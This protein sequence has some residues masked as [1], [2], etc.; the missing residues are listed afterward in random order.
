MYVI[1]FKI[2][3]LLKLNVD[4][5]PMVIVADSRDSCLE[6]R[7]RE[8]SQAE[9]ERLKRKSTGKINRAKI[10]KVEPLFK[11]SIKERMGVCGKFNALLTDTIPCSIFFQTLL[12]SLYGFNFPS[13][14]QKAAARNI[15]VSI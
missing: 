4:F 1:A 3:A 8:N 6:K 5:D 14:N 11:G 13:V 12:Y 10:K 9:S 15:R 2:K 7:V